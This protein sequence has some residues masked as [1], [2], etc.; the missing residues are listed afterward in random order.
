MLSPGAPS[1]PYL[2]EAHRSEEGRVPLTPTVSAVL[3]RCI[4]CDFLS[5]WSATGWSSPRRGSTRKSGSVIPVTGGCRGGRCGTCLVPCLAH[6]RSVIGVNLL[7][8]G[9]SKWAW[10]VQES[11]GTN[12]HRAGVIAWPRGRYL[13]CFP[14]QSSL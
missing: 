13:T 14:D 5:Q 7:S 8:W 12:L 11:Q 1:T 9:G 2:S 10:L 6:G 3:H 4:C